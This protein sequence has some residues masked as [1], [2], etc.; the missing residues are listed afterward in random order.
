[1][2]AHYNKPTTQGQTLISI[3]IAVVVFSILLHAVFT[4]VATSFDLV[5]VNRARITAKYIGL[6][7][8]ET[9]QN[10]PYEEIGTTEGI[11]NGNLAETETV[12]ING[13]N[14][15]IK[16]NVIYIDDEFDGQG[17]EDL[18]PDYKR[19]RVEVL[20]EGLAKPVKNPLVFVTDI[21]PSIAQSYLAAGT[22]QIT[23]IDANGQPVPQAVVAIFTDS[24]SPAVDI[25]LNTPDTG[26]VSIPGAL[27]C[28]ECY[29]ITATKDGYSTD[30]TYSV[31]EVTNPIKPHASV[32]ETDVTQITF[33]IDKVST[34]NVTSV[35]GRDEGF[36]PQANVSFRLRGS[37]IIGTDAFSQFVYKYDNVHSTDAGGNILLD[38][39]EWDNYFVF[40][41][42]V[43]S[44]DISGNSPLLPLNILPAESLDYT[45]AVESHTNHSLLNSVKDSSQNLIE[46]A[47]VNLTSG[48]YDEATTSGKLDDPDFGQ[49]F[50]SNLDN[51]TYDYTATASGYTDKS[52][53]VGVDGY[54]EN[55]I[56]LIPE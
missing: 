39:L 2:S 8:I 18:F 44:Y 55:N 27:P 26:I 13:L 40:M 36:I 4:L 43:T 6:E 30:R 3:L 47:Y 49:V 35:S 23:V 16:T 32:L 37:K 17:S 11:P 48:A 28:T 22:L 34:L 33:S 31:A 41:P 46:N 12:N 45:L 21:A 56:I 53:T 24:I 9:I 38:E 54:S 29:Q 52:G 20:W 19:V 25:T 5:S 15:T 50:F 42:E 1:M 51:K 10:M 7:R 14:F